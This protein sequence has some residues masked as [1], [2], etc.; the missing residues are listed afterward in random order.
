MARCACE[1]RSRSIKAR[2]RHSSRTPAS[3][4]A[5]LRSSQCVCTTKSP[6]CEA[7]VERRAAGVGI[8]RFRKETQIS[9]A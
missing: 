7:L 1:P 9:L 5:K 3:C 2:W 8:T 4:C 6:T